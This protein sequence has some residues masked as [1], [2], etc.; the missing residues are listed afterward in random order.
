MSVNNIIINNYFSEN[1]GRDNSKN[2][3]YKNNSKDVDLKKMKVAV[4]SISEF[5]SSTNTSTTTIN[6][7]T[8]ILNNTVVDIQNLTGGKASLIGGKTQT[9]I[10]AGKVV[11]GAGFTIALVQLL[12]AVVDPSKGIPAAKTKILYQKISSQNGSESLQILINELYSNKIISTKNIDDLE[13]KDFEALIA[14][15]S[16]VAVSKELSSMSSATLRE[17]EIGLNA[18]LQ[19][20]VKQFPV[21]FHEKYGNTV[22]NNLRS[23]FKGNATPSEIYKNLRIGQLSLDVLEIKNK[24][25]TKRDLVNQTIID[26]VNE[27][28]HSKDEIKFVKDWIEEAILNR[29]Y[30]KKNC[31]EQVRLMIALKKDQTSMKNF[32]EGRLKL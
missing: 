23:F 11:S 20:M 25:E 28:K 4:D 8:K 9:G 30:T 27:K 24:E 15:Y 31:K 2:I 3:Y 1:I 18:L 16:N 10:L 7:K 17:L 12:G 6:D 14:C 29:G 22:V 5:N 26:L 19:K 32:F 21:P 13:F